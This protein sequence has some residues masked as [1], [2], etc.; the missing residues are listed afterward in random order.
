MSSNLTI[1][2]VSGSGSSG[3]VSWLTT[4]F[5]TIN[6][7]NV[8]LPGPATVPELIPSIEMKDLK[9]DF[10][11]D[12]WAPPTSSSRVEAQLKNP[13]GFPLSVSQLD[14]KV[15]A[16]Y[17]GNGVAT[18]DIPTSP[19]STSASGL[20]TTGFNNIPFKVLNHELFTGFNGLL[21]LTPSVTFGL[22]GSSN[23]IANTAV[24]TLS[25]PGVPFDV[26][27]TLAGK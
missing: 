27:T 1:K 2:G 25:L 12:Q 3:T 4:A 26:D 17:G 24:G 13:F 18:L 14:M 19:A 7:E 20:I 23:A 6:I 10:T 9:L 16:T 11:K 22:K 5:K 8:V 21:T 15:E